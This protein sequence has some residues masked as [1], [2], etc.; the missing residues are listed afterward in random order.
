MEGLLATGGIA[1]ADVTRRA[2]GSIVAG[3]KS[4]NETIN[5]SPPLHRTKKNRCQPSPTAIFLRSGSVNSC[6][7]DGQHL[8]NGVAMIVGSPLVGTGVF[9]FNGERFEG[10]Q[11]RI[12]V[13]R[14]RNTQL[15]GRGVLRP[16]R[17]AFHAATDAFG[18]G[19]ASLQLATGEVLEIVPSRFALSDGSRSLEFTVNGPVP[20]FGS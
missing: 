16:P 10:A 3:L 4:S 14:V 9:I 6:P 7:Q 11:Y 17:E 12:E 20:G 18:T 5:S 8:S 2:I 13:H 19:A 15:S 1:S